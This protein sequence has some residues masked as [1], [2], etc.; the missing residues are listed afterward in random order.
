MD[1]ETDTPEHLKTWAAQQGLRKGWTLVTGGKVEM[2]K[3]V[4]HLT[5]DP[6][7]RI[8]ML[9]SFIY[10]GND[11]TNNWAATYGLAAPKELLKKSRR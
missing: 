8:E 1:P 11:K 7:G 9:S 4:G 6:L 5:G 10:I 3:L 2:A